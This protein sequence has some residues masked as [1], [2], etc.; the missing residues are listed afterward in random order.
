MKPVTALLLLVAATCF[1]LGISLP[2]A[3][4]EKLYFFEETPSLI[5]I[6]SG[7]WGDGHFALC[8][9]VALVS[10]LFPLAKMALTFLA[11]FSPTRHGLD[12]RYACWAPVLAKWSM[13]DVIIVALVVFAAKTSGLASAT[14]QP[15]LWF[16]ALSAASGAAAGGLLNRLKAGG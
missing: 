14:A 12:A 1:G 6:V 3:R 5:E 2:M 13:M 16:Y 7:L 9:V 4:F 8:L 15:G 11:A 10:I